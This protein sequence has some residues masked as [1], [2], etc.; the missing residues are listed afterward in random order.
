MCKVEGCE[1]KVYCKGY[2]HKHYAK[3]NRYGESLM[4]PIKE[5]KLCCVP[6]CDNKYLAK[7]YC[8]KHYKQIR[9]HGCITDNLSKNEIIE[10]CD[11]AEVVLYNKDDQEVARALIDLDD[12]DKIKDIRWYSREGYA[13]NTIKGKMHRIITNCPDDMVVDHINHNTLD[14]RKCN[15]RVCTYQENSMNRKPNSNNKLGVKGA[16]K[17]GDKYE[18]YIT[19]N[20][21]RI[22]IG[23]F[24]TL[25]EAQAAYNQKASE[26]YGEFSFENSQIISDDNKL[27]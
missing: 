5:K 22:Y 11:Y 2:C 9:T 13:C 8:V 6:G 25:E 7:G 10:H 14:N 21:E 1:G 16:S 18:A 26:L 23:T 20:K 3:Y 24:D 17:R 19:F 4:P 12:I 27:E 15:L